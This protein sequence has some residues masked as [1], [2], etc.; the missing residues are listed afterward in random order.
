[1]CKRLVLLTVLCVALLGPQ[2]IGYNAQKPIALTQVKSGGEALHNAMIIERFPVHS[3]IL[4]GMSDD[5]EK[6]LEEL[7]EQFRQFSDKLRRIPERQ[8]FKKPE[9]ELDRLVEEMKRAEKAAR[10]KLQKE[11]VP[12][13]KEEIKKLRERLRK[14]IK[15]DDSKPIE[16]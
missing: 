2:K 11:I 7:K 4:C 6:S 1:M 8:E 12:R 10:E 15:E 5:L 3:V 16:V 9:K 13:L 14:L